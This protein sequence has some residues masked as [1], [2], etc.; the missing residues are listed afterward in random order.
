[1]GKASFFSESKCRT[2]GKEIMVVYLHK[3]EPP[4][5][6]QPKFYNFKELLHTLHLPYLAPGFL[7]APNILLSSK[8]YKRSPSYCQ[9]LLPP[10]P[11]LPTLKLYRE[12]GV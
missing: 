4:Q 10:P 5:V 8:C 3:F 2:N 6:M 7:F 11:P 1:M 12:D 9:K